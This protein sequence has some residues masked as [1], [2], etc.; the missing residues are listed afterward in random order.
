VVEKA[1]FD[2]EHDS[3]ASSFALEFAVFIGQLAQALLFNI[4]MSLTASQS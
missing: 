3:G 1:Q 2:N 4:S